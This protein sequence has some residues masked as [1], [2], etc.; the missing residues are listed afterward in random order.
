MEAVV[1]D[2]VA[3]G[4]G[5]PGIEPFAKRLPARLDGEVDD[6]RGSTERRRPSSRLECVLGERPAERQFHVGVDVD[7]AGDQVP[8]GGIDRLIGGQAGRSEIGPDRGDD[9]VLDEDVGSGR[10]VGADDDPI[11]D[12]R[13]HPVDPP[14]FT[15]G[16]PVVREQRK[17]VRIRPAPR[18][19][20][21]GMHAGTDVSRTSG[22]D[23]GPATRG[24]GPRR[25]RWASAVSLALGG[26]PNAGRGCEDA[27]H[28]QQ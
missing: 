5:V 17:E 25:R 13:P 19:G 6:H 24:G 27:A 8:A 21:A 18:L 28:Q 22:G 7:P 16:R 26:C 1:G 2:R 11:G 4:L 3:L 14:G 10:A 20:A 23:G 12:E 9:L 15:H